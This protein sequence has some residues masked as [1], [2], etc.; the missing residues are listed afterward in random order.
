M[1]IREKALEIFLGAREMPGYD[2]SWENHSRNVA[3]V[4]ET[5][6]L[7]VRKYQEEYL[8]LPCEL[9]VD[10][11]YAA[12]LLHDIGRVIEKKPGLRHPI[13]GY[14]FL[15]SRG[16][17]IPARISMTHT[18]YGYHEID[19]T[20]FWEELDAVNTKFTREYMEK[21]RLSDVDLLI[22][23]ADHMGHNMGIMTVS[24]RFCD[25]LSR[26]GIRMATDH[27]KELFRL[28]Q[29]FDKK[30]GVNIYELFRD[31]IIRTTM[32]EPNEIIRGRQKVTD[33]TEEKI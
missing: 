2:V 19:R 22:Q 7:A 30:A 3:R 15:K 33:E 12:G 6:T 14:E 21:V 13:L 32:M 25:I 27:I 9:G 16:L 31:E 10:M 29:Y 23:L 28:K 26:H 11:A 18:Y 17:E 20:E 24:D 8:K 5:V 4:A 1:K